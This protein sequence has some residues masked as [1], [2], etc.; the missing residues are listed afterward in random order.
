MKAGQPTKYNK[1][2]LAKANVYLNEW[3]KEGDMIPSIEALAPY[4]GVSRA[5]LYNWEDKHDEF[6][7]ILDEIMAI[8]KRTLLNNGLSGDF[9]SN[10]TKLA[11]GKH[12]LSE[13]RE[14]SGVDGKDLIPSGIDTTYE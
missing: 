4:L 14:L 6:L 7:D 2:V 1:E 5:T 13:K 12:G 3:Q 9:N 10:I 8:Q 11:L